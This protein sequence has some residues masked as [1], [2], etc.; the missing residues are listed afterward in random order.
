MSIV[1]TSNLGWLISHCDYISS[2][3]EHMPLGKQMKLKKELF[4][5]NV[6]Y[7]RKN[8]RGKAPE[9]AIL[10][11]AHI[12]NVE[13]LWILDVYNSLFNDFKNHFNP[14]YG[15]IDNKCAL[16]MSA[17]VYETTKD[18]VIVNAEG[19]NIGP[20]IYRKICNGDYI[21]PENCEFFCRDTKE[22]S[23]CL[24]TKKF[25]LILLDPPWWNKYIRRKRK[26]SSHAYEMMYN[27]DL[28]DLNLES[29]LNENGLIVVWCTNSPQHI[30]ALKD[31]IFPKW[32]V[33]FISKWYWLKV[34]KRGEPICNFSEPPGKQ[35]FEQII[36]GCR[37]NRSILNPPNKKLVLSVPS[38]LH[39]HKPPL[40]DLLKMYVPESPK[41]LEIFARY[42]LPNWTSY[43]NEVLK[44]QHESL[45][46]DI[47]KEI[48]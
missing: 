16:E 40:V 18:L 2:V 27:K 24:S 29:L 48:Y 7:I 31:E 41:C 12:K 38:A 45:Y 39:S 42:L 10:K 34:T 1:C 22:I 44:F 26:R 36:F 14:N 19:A 21:F 5:I 13:V 11:K 46:D 15:E 4:E 32:G 6:P 43:G 35:P 33:Q 17:K 28:K 3:Y 25:D 47:P 30:S 23:Q 20:N 9:C 8:K 37:N